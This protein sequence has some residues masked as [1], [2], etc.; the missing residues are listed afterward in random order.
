[1][2]ITYTQARALKTNGVFRVDRGLYAQV[3]R[4]GGSITWVFRYRRNGRTRFMGLGPLAEVNLT[5]ARDLADEARKLIRRGLD[6]IEQRRADK[7][8]TTITFGEATKRFIAAHEKGWTNPKHRYQIERWL[9][10]YAKS[11]ASMSVDAIESN[12]VIK[13]V[14]PIW[15]TKTETADRVRFYIGRVLDWAKAAGFR[16]GDNPAQWKG[17]LEHRLPAASKLKNVEHHEAVPVDEAPALFAKLAAVPTKVSLALRFIA[18]TAVRTGE[19][20]GATWDEFDI[21]ARLWV[22]PAERMKMR[23]EHRVPLSEAAV[24]IL[25]A[26][27]GTR[28]HPTGLVFHGA[29]RAKRISDASL[30]K[31]MRKFGTEGVTT[32]G[33]RSTFRD[34][35]ATKT[36]YPAMVAEAS[37]AHLLGS[38]TEVAYLRSD[39]FE[40]R[41][42]LMKDWSDYLTGVDGA[43][44]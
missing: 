19:A 32:H 9:T 24:A 12:H 7:G 21:E 36:D 15:S 41:T 16:T 4:D 33:W 23:K 13:C 39:L 22:I 26:L 3:R 8:E 14:E 27:R 11:L 35:V 42:G 2:P 43:A 37:L 38:K 40:Q 25:E 5:E 20:L 31:L 10:V 6:P 18:L 1:M 28:K 44:S 29:D 34:W 17:S 30:R